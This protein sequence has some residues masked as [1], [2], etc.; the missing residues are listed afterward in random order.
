MLI[1]T[2]AHLDFPDFEQDLDAVISRARAAGVTRIITIG[3]GLETSARAVALTEKYPGVVFA[4]VGIHPNHAHEERPDFAGPLRDLAKHPNVV[5][6]GEIGIDHHYLPEAEAARAEVLERQTDAYRI[7]LELAV[8]LGFNVVIHQRDAWEP[9]LAG[10]HPFHGK[11]HGVWHCFGGTPAQMNRLIGHGHY[12]S[13]TGI[14]TFK[15]APVVRDSAML[16]PANHYMVET[17]CPYLAPVPFRSQRCEPAHTRIVA[18]CIAKER[19]IT[20]EEVAAET[21]RN[22]ERF[23]RFPKG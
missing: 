6:I 9:V 18:E 12:V 21:T 1:D 14:V 10:V 2:H 8:E 19:R 3:T 11:L 23:F 7:Q 20:L 17:D 5:A 13:F 16:A 4:A 22:A 15:N